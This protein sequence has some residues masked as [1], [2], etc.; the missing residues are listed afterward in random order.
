MSVDVPDF[1]EA[2][3]GWKGLH[4]DE[5][6][7]LH[8]PSEVTRWPAGARL[9][10][11]CKR[12]DHT[13]PGEHCGCGIY[14]VNSF[15]ALKAAGYN[16]QAEYTDHGLLYVAVIAEVSLWGRVVPGLIGFRAQ[17][18]YPQK[19]YVPAWRWQLGN[20]IKRRY[21]CELG[22]IDRFTGERS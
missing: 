12:R 19:V 16:W 7:Q 14:A 17:Y 10:A 22:F 21:D 3:V 9:E 13:P 1:I 11:E 2:L 8:S 15:D 6:G 18:A 4:A 5:R 20:V